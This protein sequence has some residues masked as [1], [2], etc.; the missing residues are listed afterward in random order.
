MDSVWRLAA[1]P[2]RIERI[3]AQIGRMGHSD[4]SARACKQGC[5]QEEFGRRCGAPC[6]KGGLFPSLPAARRG[7]SAGITAPGLAPLHSH[8]SRD[9]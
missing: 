3:F 2:Q 1:E 7:I 5:P 4:P 6:C 9:R 8:S